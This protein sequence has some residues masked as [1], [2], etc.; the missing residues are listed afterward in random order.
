MN[1]LRYVLFLATVDIEYSVESLKGLITTFAN[2][3]LTLFCAAC[4]V[5]ASIHAFSYAKADDAQQKQQSKGK[6]VNL[7]VAFVVAFAAIAFIN[8]SAPQITEWLKNTLNRVN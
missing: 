8:T 3:A 4:T 1:G 6:I 2:A 5:L 7:I